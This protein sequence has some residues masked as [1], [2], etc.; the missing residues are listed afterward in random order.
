[1][2]KTLT[3]VAF[4]AA[5]ALAPIPALAAWSAPVSM[6]P[7]TTLADISCTPAGAGRVACAARRTQNRLQVNVYNGGTWSGWTLLAGVV[8]TSP[9]CADDGAGKV[10]CAAGGVGYTLV[11]TVFDGASF[12]PLAVAPGGAITSQPSC[13]SPS[14]GNFMCLARSLTGGLTWATYGGAWSAF[15]Q[16]ATPAYSAPGCA[17][18]RMGN[19]ICA[20]LT[21]TGHP[22]AL[23]FDGANWTPTLDIGA[24]GVG[25]I[26]PGISKPT[27][28]EMGTPGLVSCFVEK[29]NTENVFSR[30]LGGAWTLAN[31][32]GGCGVSGP[33]GTASGA[34]SCGVEGPT[35]IICGFQAAGQYASALWTTEIDA[36]GNGHYHVTAPGPILGMPGCAG[37][38]DGRVLCALT[39]ANN[40]ATSVVG[41]Q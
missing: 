1:M 26:I 37:L 31:W 32:C 9:S 35:R 19:A 6:G 13:A 25:N 34:A 22:L 21:N 29:I 16:I 17:P 23:R 30:F 8:S 20:F 10:L 33:L 3:S 41:Q 11:A 14:A 36:S 40:R 2:L 27:C 39:G 38:G 18:D 12:G 15:G 24:T 4:A 28:A 7:S 5:C